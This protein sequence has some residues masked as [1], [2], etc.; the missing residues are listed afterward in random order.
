MKGFERGS[1]LSSPEGIIIPC[2]KPSKAL[3]QSHLQ[4]RTAVSI[5]HGTVAYRRTVK[6][7]QRKGKRGGKE[8]KKKRTTER[9]QKGRHK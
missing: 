6:G 7:R 1:K 9:R 2:W 4:V 3:E 8:S 5:G